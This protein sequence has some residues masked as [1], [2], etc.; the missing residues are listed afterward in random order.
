MESEYI[1]AN[2]HI[3]YSGK[4]ENTGCLSF[5]SPSQIALLLLRI[6][7]YK[8]IFINSYHVTVFALKM[9]FAFYL[10]E[11]NLNLCIGLVAIIKPSM[12]AKINVFTLSKNSP[13]RKTN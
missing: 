7:C 6:I 13:T 4:W 9:S 3:R 11:M 10:L 8:C 2:L 5:Y 1:L 12:V